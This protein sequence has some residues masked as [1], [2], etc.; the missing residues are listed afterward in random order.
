MNAGGESSSIVVSVKGR[1]FRKT[2]LGQTAAFGRLLPDAIG[3]K[4]RSMAGF[5]IGFSYGAGSKLL[6]NSSSSFRQAPVITL[7]PTA[8]P[9]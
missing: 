1:N 8:G 2:G 5:V 4:A 7:F 3:K 6:R 9:E